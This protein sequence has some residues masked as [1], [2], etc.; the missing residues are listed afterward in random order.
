MGKIEVSELFYKGKL[1]W[2][3]SLNLPGKISGSY[4]S[5]LAPGLSDAHAHPQVIDVGNG[6]KWKNSY[7]WI[8]KRKLR[9]REGD[10]RKDIELS[11]KL[12]S[13]TFKLSLLDGVTMIAVTGSLRGNIEAI[14]RMKIRPKIVVLPTVMN[15][16]GWLNSETLSREIALFAGLDGG[17]LRGGIFIHSLG[18]TDP[19]T[20]KEAVLLSRRYRI[21]LS[22]HLNEGV[23]EIEKLKEI[24]DG[25]MEGIIAVHCIE[26]PNRCKEHGLRIIS[27]PLSNLYLYGRTIRLIDFID[28]FGSDWPLVTGTMKEVLSKASEIFISSSDKVLTK[29]TLG[30]YEIFEMSSIG[31]YVFYDES[32]ESVASG[33][34]RPKLVVVG[35]METV[36][37]GKLEGEG[38]EEVESELKETIE[39]ALEKYSS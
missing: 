35:G 38:R 1:Y 12:A 28:A 36:V 13:I 16:D 15:M 23:E 25:E 24:M 20:A 32:L 8:S 6:G 10:L 3:V 17:K 30:G 2:D 4:R 27:C 34:A 31:D 19:S 18:L 22:M 9:L 33:R 14:K 39:E 21:P 37:E 29:A 7:E 11:S 5:A 26:E